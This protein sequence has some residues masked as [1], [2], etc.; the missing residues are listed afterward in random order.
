MEKVKI[1]ILGV[2]TISGIYLEN[3]TKVFYGVKVEGVCDLSR[4]RAKEAAEKYKIPKVY[5]DYE[6]MLQDPD[7]ELVLNL[8]RPGEHYKVI[9]QALETGKNV[10]TEK[11][12]SITFGEGR[13][14]VDL[15]MQKGLYLGGAPDTFL[16][17]GIQTCR[18]LIDEG[19]IGK[20]IGAAVRMISHGPESWHPA[21]AFYYQKGG[22]PMMDMGPYYLTALVY[23]L[24]R[25]KR[26]S[27]MCSKGMEQRTI[28]SQAQYGAKVDVEIPTNVNGLMEFESGIIGTI[29]TTF[30]VFYDEQSFF[31]VYG[32]QGTLRVPDPNY[33]GGP[34]YL[35][36]PEMNRF[37]EM[38]VLFPYQENFR[39][40]G[41]ADM[42]SAMRKGEKSRAN[43][44]QLLHVLEAMEA[45]EKSSEL[46]K[47]VELSTPY[48]RERPMERGGILG[49]F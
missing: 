2:G 31:E 16:G 12:L 18:N 37:C 42:A 43:A 11:P 5:R 49:S 17:A 45:F 26:I 20:P 38:P 13:E 24:G 29:T 9:K 1:G 3:L 7:V 21:P 10:Y 46:G 23:L 30:D 32:T 48:E 15:A 19:F 44:G 22:G 34:I 40:L 8:S 39:G 47:T 25:I 14:L 27:G 33:F 36:R 6:E 4:E 41:V 28:T 35:F